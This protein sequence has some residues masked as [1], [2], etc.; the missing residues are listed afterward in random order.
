MNNSFLYMIIPIIKNTALNYWL[1]G[2]RH[3]EPL[4]FHAVNLKRVEPVYLNINA[5][6][7]IKKTL[8]VDEDLDVLTGPNA[9]RRPLAGLTLYQGYNSIPP[10][11]FV[12]IAEMGNDI[13]CMAS[14]EMCFLYAASVL[15]LHEVVYVGNQLCAQ[16]VTDSDSDIGQRNRD[17][18]T[19]VNKIK[20]FLKNADG[21]KGIKKAR[22]A[23]K[24]VVDGCNSP[25][26]V[27][28]A[29]IARLPRHYGGYGL[30]EFV[31][32]G[33][34]KLTKDGS[35]LVGYDVLRADM[36]WYKQ[37]KLVEY[38][39]NLVHLDKDQHEH[40]KKRSNAIQKAGYGVTYIT[41][42]Q[43]SGF[44]PVEDTFTSLQKE[45]GVRFDR[46]K[47]AEQQEK[48]RKVVKDLLRR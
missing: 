8:C 15:P 30:P 1:D 5:I 19:N 29:A 38:E 33:A 23:I 32:N 14:P 42:G 26:E 11:S 4:V 24:Y 43:V 7:E 31:M 10:G 17:P 46:A 18:I 13:L 12:K 39:S 28:L 37:R 35:S 36:V 21:L 3:Y 41:A 34:V 20:R 25:K 48:R 45:L 16:Y 2:T 47:F 22:T 27:F 40:D 6:E 44:G 9:T